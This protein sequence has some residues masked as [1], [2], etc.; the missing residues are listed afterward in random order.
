MRNSIAFPFNIIF[1][2]KIINY[3]IKTKYT[4]HKKSTPIQLRQGW[5]N[6]KS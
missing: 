4:L 2:C 5:I 3:F 6:Y 1:F